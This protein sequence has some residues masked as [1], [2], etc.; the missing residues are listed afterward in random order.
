MKKIVLTLLA[1][2]SFCMVAEAQVTLTGKQY[3]GRPGKNAELI[4]KPIVIKEAMRIVKITGD[5]R[6]FR[7][8]K[9]TGKTWQYWKSND[10]SAIGLVLQPG[11]Y[12]VYPNLPRYGKNYANV[13][14]V[15]LTFR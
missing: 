13:G 15:T 11:R 8:T 9:G 10:K 14:T 12:F 4:C 5:N 7:I 1:V 6:G 2:I 3:K